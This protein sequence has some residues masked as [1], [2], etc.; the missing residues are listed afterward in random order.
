MIKQLTLTVLAASVLSACSMAPKYTRPDAPVA[1]DYPVASA[2]ADKQQRAYET[3][4]RNFF[5]DQR[6]QA[7]ISACRR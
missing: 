2:A 1:A 4:W 6:L 5:P 7:L 3:G